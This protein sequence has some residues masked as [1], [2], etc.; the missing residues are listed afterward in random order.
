VTVSYQPP[1]G[2]P[3]VDSVKTDANGGYGDT[4]TINSAETGTWTATAHFAGDA[5]RTSADS[6]TCSFVVTRATQSASLTLG[7]P[8][9][10]TVSSLGGTASVGGSLMPAVSGSAVTV[11]YQPPSGQPI[12]DSVR[13]DAGGSYG[14]TVDIGAS[15]TGTW[16][17]T[18][19]F[20]G[21]A[22]RTSADS[23]PCSFVVVRQPQ[24][25]L[26]IASVHGD[27]NDICSIYA[28]VQ[29]IGTAGAPATKTEFKDLANP[30][31]FDQ[32]V[33]T[34]AI[35]AGQTVTVKLARAYGQ[36][37]GATV[38]ADATNLA[39]ESNET[40]NTRTGFAYLATNGNC[41]YP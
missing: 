30:S 19:H 28:D 7:C 41:H 31:T 13:T 4:V 36:N 35:P 37:D 38:T 40:N 6:A 39:T 33:D 23:P 32:L 15:Q 29:N 26:V 10:V 34:P 14:D 16:T 25:D 3:I 9:A 18:A 22:T 2:Q 21:D 17:A 12:V 8:S 24:P 1:S 5:I 11:S 27:A 20:A